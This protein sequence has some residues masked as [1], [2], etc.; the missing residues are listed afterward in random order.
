MVKVLMVVVVVILA[1]VI[2][3]ALRPDTI[4][5]Q[6]AVIIKA[7]PEKIFALIDDFHRWK[8][9]APQDKEDTTMSRSYGG[10]ASGAGAASRWS[11]SGSAGQGEMT[12]RESVAPRRIVVEVD[13]V[14]PFAAHNVNE[15]T[16]EPAEGSSGGL[17]QAT[18]V[19]W[20]MQGT[21]LFIMKVMSVFVNM[22]R[23]V[24]KHFESGLGNLKAVAEGA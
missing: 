12:I 19:T 6:R 23:V 16:L 5:L 7:P 20:K 13:W 2:F 9:W 1:I 8:E 21:N 11:S 24:G 15:F 10:P 4:R 17:Q 22:D 3:A 18:Q 14:K